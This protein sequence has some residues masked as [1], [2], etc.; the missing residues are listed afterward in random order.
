LCLR[1][2]YL[3][4]RERSYFCFDTFYSKTWKQKMFPHLSEFEPSLLIIL[5]SSDASL[6]STRIPYS[7]RTSP[8][9][10]TSV[11]TQFRSWTWSSCWTFAC[12]PFLHSLGPH[13]HHEL[14]VRL[15]EYI[16]N[17]HNFSCAHCGIE[18]EKGKK[19]RT[20]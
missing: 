3:K 4:I 2:R 13:P 8:S 9:T 12:L 6:D 16:N 10:Q 5:L 19:T 17:R 1:G 18:R 11:S 7:T 15:S 20:E 14:D